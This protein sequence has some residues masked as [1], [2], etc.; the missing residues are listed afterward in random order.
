M[1]VKVRAAKRAFCPSTLIGGLRIFNRAPAK[2]KSVGR[3]VGEKN[4][5]GK[6]NAPDFSIVF[7]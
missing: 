5:R 3:K 7:R 1:S 4:L 2:E 6:S